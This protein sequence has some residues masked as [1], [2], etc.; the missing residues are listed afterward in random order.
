MA[1]PLIQS[2]LFFSVYHL[3][4]LPPVMEE[5]ISNICSAMLPSLGMF[6]AEAVS[7]LGPPTKGFSTDA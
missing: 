1:S 2:S 4:Q 7:L 5:D 3:T 6:S